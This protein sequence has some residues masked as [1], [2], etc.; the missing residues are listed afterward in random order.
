M[1][2]LGTLPTLHEVCSIHLWHVE[3]INFMGLFIIF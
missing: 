1:E 2:F 3:I